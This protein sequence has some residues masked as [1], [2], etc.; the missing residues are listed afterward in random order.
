VK[1]EKWFRGRRELFRRSQADETSHQ[2]NQL[3]QSDGNRAGGPA[4][5]RSG[6]VKIEQPRRKFGCLILI[7]TRSASATKAAV[8]LELPVAGRALQEIRA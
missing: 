2:K 6:V 5:S 8:Q 1:S 7:R 3:F 4:R